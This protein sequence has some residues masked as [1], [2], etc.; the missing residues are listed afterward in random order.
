M[1]TVTVPNPETPLTYGTC[2]VYVRHT[3]VDPAGGDNPGDPTPWVEVVGLQ[4]LEVVWSV[5]PSMPTAMLS[6]DYGR[7]KGNASQEWV[8]RPK[9]TIERWF[10][11][12]VADMQ[13]NTDPGHEGEW[14]QRTWVGVA[15]FS[16]DRQGGNYQD[17]DDNQVAKGTQLWTC[18]GMEQLLAEH[19]IRTAVWRDGTT[20][21]RIG[22]SLD[23]NARRR[24]RTLGNRTATADGD[25][26]YQFAK[27]PANAATWSTADIVKYLLKYHTPADVDYLPT[28]PFAST[29]SLPTWDQPVLT[30]DG[31]TTYSIISQLIDRRRLRVWWL[32]FDEANN[33]MMFEADTLTQSAITLPITGSP[34]IPANGDQIELWFDESPYVTAAVRSPAT[35]V[36]DQVV[37]VGGRRRCVGSFS[38]KDAT[39]TDGWTAAQETAYKAGATGEAGYSTWDRKKKQARNAEVRGRPFL[40]NVFSYF[41]IPATWNRKV[42][43]GENAGTAQWLFPFEQAAQNYNELFLEQSLPLLV[44]VDYSGTKL[45]DGTVDETTGSGQELEPLVF[46]RKPK[47]NKEAPAITDPVAEGFVP[48]KWM[49]ADVAGTLKQLETLDS[50]E[51]HNFTCDVSVPAFAK[52]VR[53][54]VTGQPQHAM[55][56]YGWP[57]LTRGTDEERVGHWDY[58]DGMIITLSIPEDVPINGAYPATDDVTAANVR[59]KWIDTG[60][61]YRETYVAPQTVVDVATDGSLV[62]STGG[63]FPPRDGNHAAKQLEAVAKIAY[64][65]YGY[66]HYAVNLSSRYLFTAAEIDLGTLIT[67]INNSAGSHRK[68]VNT[69]ITQLRLEWPLGTL[70]S[71]DAPQLSFQ[72]WAGELDQ[73]QLEVKPLPTPLRITQGAGSSP[74]LSGETRIPTQLSTRGNN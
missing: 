16:D 41:I 49:R 21:Y 65:W 25:G 58:H 29:I 19:E 24:D 42:K 3:W 20:Y 2:K 39:L 64:Q 14:H 22:R 71:T 35:E 51:D 63:Y 46:L 27:D 59:R 70:E 60:E 26:F 33:R 10:V 15:M 34:T 47:T 43:N 13:P 9:L 62:R 68:T 73:F 54:E 74:Y 50:K 17:A 32:E 52:G 69:V 18:H 57:T 67:A 5:A 36:V 4:A 1:T 56:Q 37:A 66:A 45:T 30:T 53:V 11:K 23:F 12:I 28:V 31:K 38:Y 8:I 72:T 61:A 55:A 7:V 40:Q 6:W 48:W 44:G